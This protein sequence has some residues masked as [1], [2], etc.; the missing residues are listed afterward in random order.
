MNKQQQTQYIL[1]TKL[2]QMDS[3]NLLRCRFGNQ[4][5]ELSQEQIKAATLSESWAFP[6]K[7]LSSLHIQSIYRYN[8]A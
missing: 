3:R 5:S 4:S 8:L 2:N 1:L 7:I 6:R